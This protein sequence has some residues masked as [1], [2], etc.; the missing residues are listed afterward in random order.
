MEKEKQGD[1]KPGKNFDEILAKI[2]DGNNAG[3]FSGKRA[4]Y[5]AAKPLLP[6]LRLQDVSSFLHRQNVY[7]S[8][9]NITRKFPRRQYV[10]SAPGSILGLDLVFIDKLRPY[11]FGFGI[12]LTA[13]DF[14]TR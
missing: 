2:Y 12:I 13:T 5:E 3:A 11:N 7:I 4:L 8:H 6:Q 14:F 10:S 1:S 9:K